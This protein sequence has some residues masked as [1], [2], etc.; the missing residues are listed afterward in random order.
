MPPSSPTVRQ[1]Q[2]RNLRNNTDFSKKLFLLRFKTLGISIKKLITKEIVHR[3]LPCRGEK[4]KIGFYCTLFSTE[5][6]KTMHAQKV[7]PDTLNDSEHEDYCL[8]VHVV[9]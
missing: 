3:S 1:G 4:T 2:G 7:R 8:F 9:M 6:A 5:Q